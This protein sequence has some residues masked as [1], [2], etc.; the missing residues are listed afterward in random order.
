MVSPAHKVVGGYDT[1]RCTN[2]STAPRVYRGSI[3]LLKMEKMTLDEWVVNQIRKEY[4]DF[5]PMTPSNLNDLNIRIEF[6]KKLLDSR[7]SGV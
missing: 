6:L 7:G 4:L 3:N 5:F 2:Y 1:L